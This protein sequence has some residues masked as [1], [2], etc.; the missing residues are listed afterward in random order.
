[1]HKLALQQHQLLCLEF[2][3]YDFL[4]R[5]R[6][7]ERKVS[8]DQATEHNHSSWNDCTTQGINGHFKMPCRYIDKFR[9]QVD[10][11]DNKCIKSN[12]TTSY[13][14]PFGLANNWKR[15]L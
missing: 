7:I 5:P 6:E 13:A 10:G 14:R 8:H 3:R 11:P 12:A 4:P 9:K 2:H 15:I 1:M